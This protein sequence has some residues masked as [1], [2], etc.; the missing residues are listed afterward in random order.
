MICAIVPRID[1][2]LVAITWSTLKTSSNLK[3]SFATS[4]RC[5]PLQCIRLVLQAQSTIATDSEVCQVMRCAITPYGGITV[6][7]FVI[8]P[9]RL[10][11]D[12][13]LRVSE[14]APMFRV[15]PRSTDVQPGSHL[16]SCFHQ[17]SVFRQLTIEIDS[18]RKGT[19]ASRKMTT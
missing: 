8:T 3:A 9:D 10:K 7:S 18:H 4:Y 19:F 14:S 5:H 17:L 6:C 15:Q 13:Y 12:R 16:R 11:M 2:V 1:F